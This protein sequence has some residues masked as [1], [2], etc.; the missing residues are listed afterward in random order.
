MI[1]N[2]NSVPARIVIVGTSRMKLSE[3][4]SQLS[5]DTNGNIGVKASTY[6]TQYS[7]G[8]GGMVSDRLDRENTMQRSFLFDDYMDNDLFGRSGGGRNFG[9]ARQQIVRKQRAAP[10]Q[11]FAYDEI[12]DDQD[13]VEESEARLVDPL[14][15]PLDAY[16]DLTRARRRASGRGSFGRIRGSRGSS[17][18][19]VY[20][21]PARRFR[22]PKAVVAEDIY[23]YYEP[24]PRP[25]MRQRVKM[26]TPIHKRV[27]I[28][29]LSRPSF[30]SESFRKPFRAG[31]GTRFN[32]GGAGGGRGRG[33][34]RGGRKNTLAANKQLPKKK[35]TPEELDREL[36]M[37]MN[38]GKHPR[39]A[40]A[41]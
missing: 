12:Y 20:S 8:T 21:V 17:Q 38:S 18:F 34:F 27:S 19:Q 5:S 23:E 33:G 28:K 32:R 26:R 2:I 11:R 14:S 6:R 4:F 40:A 24:L 25:S 36:E 22:R 35:M 15:L 39:V 29:R 41:V 3:R 30:T 10:S 1:D 31:G 13:I 9:E 7:N 16:R 37:Y